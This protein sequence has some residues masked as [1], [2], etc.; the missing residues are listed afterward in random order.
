[1]LPSRT[2]FRASAAQ[3]GLK[4]EAEFAFG[5]D[6]AKTLCIWRDN[7]NHRLQEV[8]QLGFDEAFIRL[9]NF[10]LMYCSAGFSERNIDVVQ[11]TLSHETSVPSASVL[12]T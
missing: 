8:R 11:F 9:W 3:A 4:V 12:S 1:M 7:F 5:S 10:Y 6:Y 2:S